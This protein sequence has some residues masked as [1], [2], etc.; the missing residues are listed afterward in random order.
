MSFTPYPRNYRNGS[1]VIDNAQIGTNTKTL[2]DNTNQQYFDKSIELNRTYG[3]YKKYWMGMI[4]EGNK[5]SVGGASNDNN[6]FGIC[7]QPDD[8]SVAEPEV[9]LELNKDGDLRI[10]G[11]IYIAGEAINVSN[12]HLQ[13]DDIS[14]NTYKFNG[15]N[16]YI[17]HNQI[18]IHKDNNSPTYTLD[19]LHN[20]G[21][22]NF[23]QTEHNFSYGHYLPYI[24][25]SNASEDGNF[26]NICSIGTYK[27]GNNDR[28]SLYFAVNADDTSFI[29][30]DVSNVMTLTG[31]TT[32]GDRGR[33]SV[34]GDIYIQDNSKLL[35]GTG[36][37]DIGSDV[38]GLLNITCPNGLYQNSSTSIQQFLGAEHR[39]YGTGGPH[40][41]DANVLVN[42]DLTISGDLVDV[43]SIQVS[44]ITSSNSEVNFDANV[45]VNGDLT[46]SGDLVDV[47]S[48]QV[49]SITSSNSEVNF[50]KNIVVQNTYGSRVRTHLSD[51]QS[52]ISFTSGT[53]NAN[54]GYSSSGNDTLHITTPGN[55][56][57]S[58]SGGTL[59][60]N[61]NN[62]R[63]SVMIEAPSFNAT[64]DY[65]TKTNIEELDE[66]VSV[67]NLRP[68]MYLKKGKKEIGLIAHELQE[69]YPFMVSGEKDGKEMQ[70]V[71]YNCLIGVLI[72]DVKR[73][74]NENEI[75]KLN[76]DT[77]KSDYDTLKSDYDTLKSRLD[78]LE[79]KFNKKFV[80]NQE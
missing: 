27:P 30:G 72:N 70:S 2:N 7:V 66:N 78:S 50:D 18:V 47:S 49:S 6:S 68:L 62:I 55:I 63:S 64:S 76:N 59:S 61:D 35:L 41:D 36:G 48:I 8:G 15:S 33:L 67:S 73:L 22:I 38:N 14:A 23:P 4:G 24:E 51:N 37:S 32:N 74:T 56:W 12:D 25:W 17:G 26:D 9:L 11:D 3:G 46:I 52:Y 58:F 71:N 13:V 54:I 29:N 10:R 69:V 65:R 57:F 39:F 19:T 5:T 40:G 45:L 44:S 28:G 42:G 79:E 77:L 60:L 31:G 1:V 43:S 16:S 80:D 53:Y 75:L 20:N 34:P 21:V